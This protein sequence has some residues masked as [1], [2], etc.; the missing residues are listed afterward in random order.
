MAKITH[1]DVQG[2]TTVELESPEAFQAFRSGIDDHRA[3][4]NHPETAELHQV[5]AQQKSH[6]RVFVKYNDFSKRIR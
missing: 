2:I 1:D 6:G 5:N 4:R 3:W